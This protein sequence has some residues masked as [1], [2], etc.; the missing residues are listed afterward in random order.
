MSKYD[1]RHKETL[2]LFLREYFELFFPDLAAKM[3]F[4]TAHF[5]DK[6]LIA[7][8][9]HPLTAGKSEGSALETST[10]MGRIT[11][12]LVLVEVELAGQKEWILIY[13]EQ[14]STKKA[15]YEKRMFHCFCGIYFKYRKLVFPI[16][17][18]TDEAVWRKPVSNR[19]EMSILNYPVVQ[20]EYRL[21]KLKDFSSTEFEE[22]L[23]QNPLAAA[24]LPLTAY[25][26]SERPLI[27]AK[28]IK[29]IAQQVESSSK[30]AVLVSLVEISMNLS[31]DEEK[32]FKETIEKN[33]QFKE[34][35]MLQSV[36]EWGME[37]G[38][39]KGLEKGRE[40]TAINLLKMGVLSMEQIAAATD[41]LLEKIESL[42]E[43][44]ENA[45]LVH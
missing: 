4:E 8:F 39:E 9:E 41:L 5:L 37:K 38:M 31:K 2:R 43:A 16:A 13:W 22:K 34:V 24:Y 21:I 7:I 44:L 10:D 17:M 18:F 36:E 14:Q 26:K 32:R 1:V 42:A 28:A 45:K 40:A 27:M 19:F 33:D 25:Q 12:A 29:G 35:K 20:Y 30:K 15:D 3:K 6:E 23:E 11:D